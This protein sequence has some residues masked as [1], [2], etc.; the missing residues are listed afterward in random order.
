MLRGLPLLLVGVFRASLHPAVLAL[1]GSILAIVVRFEPE[2][3][4][5]ERRERDAVAQTTGPS[6]HG[7]VLL[8][9]RIVLF[10]QGRCPS[11]DRWRRR[12]RKY[13][14]AFVENR[15]AIV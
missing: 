2:A 13:V 1:A 10:G 11:L 6:W 8:G 3:A 5:R 4:V 12:R 15:D 9:E 7:I 14:L